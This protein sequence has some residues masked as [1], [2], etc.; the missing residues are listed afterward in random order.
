MLANGPYEPSYTLR[1]SHRE[2]TRG[3]TAQRHPTVH[4][5]QRLV[6]LVVWNGVASQWR[7]I[8]SAHPPQ[9]GSRISRSGSPEVSS[10][11]A[12][13]QA[14]ETGLGA[15]LETHCVSAGRS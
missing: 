12:A 11:A 2:G 6:V 3:V 15:C 10:L 4:S 5:T 9:D 14:E 7:E 8:P 13:A 1:T